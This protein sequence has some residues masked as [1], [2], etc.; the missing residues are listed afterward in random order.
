MKINITIGI[1]IGLVILVRQCERDPRVLTFIEQQVTRAM[2]DSLACQVSG[3][4]VG[5]SLSSASLEFVDFRVRPHN[6]PYDRW[7]W[8]CERLSLGA[9]WWKLVSQWVLGLSMH[10]TAMKIESQVTDG[11]VALE[12]H[13][14]KMVE[15]QRLPIPLELTKIQL[16]PM[17][18]TL[19]DNHNKH[20][21]TGT[22][23]LEASA[24]RQ[25]ALL[26][27][28][29]TDW[30]VVYHN[31]TKLTCDRGSVELHKVAGEADLHAS[32][33]IDLIDSNKQHISHRITGSYR[34]QQG[35]VS[36][37]GT[38]DACLLNNCSIVPTAT[39][40]TCAGTLSIPLKLI[41][42]VIPDLPI[43]GMIHATG[44]ID[45][46]G[47]GISVNGS[48]RVELLNYGKT[49]MVPELTAQIVA[50]TNKIAIDS[51]RCDTGH[52]ILTGS[53]TYL[54]PDG[55]IEARMGNDTDLVFPGGSIDAGS[56]SA[57]CAA[58]RTGSLTSSAQ[59]AVRM[60]DKSPQP[61]TLAC[62][63]EWPTYGLKA[64]YAGY[65]IIGTITANDGI[66]VNRLVC[67]NGDQTIAQAQGGYDKEG[68]HAALNTDLDTLLPMMH[69]YAG[70]KLAG[71]GIIAL[72]GSYTDGVIRSHLSFGQG[73]LRIPHTYN[74]IS[75]IDTMLS[76][77]AR[78]RQLA[79]DNLK[80]QCVK[81]SLECARGVIFHDQ[82]YALSAYMIPISCNGCQFTLKKGFF[83]TCS[84][85]I[86]AQQY[87][88][89]APLLSGSL[90]IDRAQCKEN[91]FALI[92]RNSTATTMP[93][94]AGW[95]DQLRCSIAVCSKD[96]IRIQTGLLDADVHVNLMVGNTLA[97]PTLEGTI[98]IGSGMVALPYKPLYISKGLIRFPIDKPTEP[99]FDLVLKNSIKQYAVTMHIA[100]TLAHPNVTVS[101]SPT[102]AQDRI[103][104]LLLAGSTDSL[105]GA[106]PAVLL[107]NMKQLL[108]DTE[109][110]PSKLHTALS[111]LFAPFK[112]VHLIPSF[113]DQTS[114]GGL[115][116]AIAIDI[117]ERWRALIQKNFSLTEDTRFEL[118]YAISD[119]ILV[120]GV[121]DERR[122]ID[123]E[124]EWKWK[125]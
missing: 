90:V 91:L 110:T 74:C 56:L 82:D 89:S 83:I 18:V 84:G 47:N 108:F 57:T 5:A 117:G 80:I 112:Y 92:G 65:E 125:F 102:L 93:G 120:R 39:G 25:C 3:R 19:Y 76:Y 71:S 35:T 38:P 20:R 73:A 96:P 21:I 88:G 52:G 22:C 118:E 70:I 49:V 30:R 68:I 42:L 41:R 32:V 114:R 124:L 27:A 121:R 17:Q 109:H 29:M 116:G 123:A 33:D 46:G 98:K 45:T 1:F 95:L 60:A 103:I 99:M 94:F 101:S 58:T 44:S 59:C 14:K 69:N 64:A 62:L 87:L 31:I 63:G 66:R 48:C 40:V 113:S 34:N 75:G 122:D 81:G 23:E 100:G 54:V 37:E 13:I 15:E 2:S 16:S 85:S 104:S 105:T 26:R 61:L 115:R 97:H 51:V 12:E 50:N 11:K 78:L 7:G 9:S 8:S 79:I 106:V 43:D 53:V 4:L 86:V 10:I 72:E 24:T 28:E 67:K 36:I 119:D 6:A 107:Q 55:T 77:D 111:Q